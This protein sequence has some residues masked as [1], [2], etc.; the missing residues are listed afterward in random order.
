MTDTIDG[1]YGATIAKR[2]LAMILVGL[3]LERGLTASKV[4]AGLG[5]GRGKLGRFEMNQWKRPELSDIRDLLR[6]YQVGPREQHRIVR[7]ALLARHRPWWREYG[8]IFST[9]YPGFEN[10]ARQITVFLPLS[11]PPLLQTRAYTQAHADRLCRSVRWRDRLVEATAGRQRILL[12]AGQLAPTMAAVITEAALY[13]NWGTCAERRE[14]IAHLAMLAARPNIEI[15]LYPFEAGPHP[16]PLGPICHLRF[17]SG[18][19]D[20][21]FLDNALATTLVTEP[22]HAQVHEEHLAL[23][24]QRA[25]DPAT[26]RAYLIRLA[27]SL[28]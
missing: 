12:R 6:L 16:E 7:L 21:V 17:D 15:R 19:P 18:D 13:Y 3:R 10:D 4:C 28:C 2:R 20:L 8:D 26:T 14:Q 5:W 22:A 25:S 1:A 24:H 11:V 23:A 27:G 9:E